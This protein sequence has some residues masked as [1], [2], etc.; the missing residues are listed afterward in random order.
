MPLTHIISTIVRRGYLGP[1]SV[2]IMGECQRRECLEDGRGS[3]PM[4]AQAAG[5]ERTV[6]PQ[7]AG[8]AL[9]R[10]ARGAVFVI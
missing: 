2:E 5:H 3:L 10:V 7:A 8:D 9:E 4:R 1:F 6:A